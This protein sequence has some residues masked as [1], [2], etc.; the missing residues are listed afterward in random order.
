MFSALLCLRRRREAAAARGPAASSTITPG[1]AHHCHELSRVTRPRDITQQM[2]G[3]IINSR[4]TATTENWQ[5]GLY[6]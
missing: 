4:V 1:R 2:L 3:S 6:V 5:A